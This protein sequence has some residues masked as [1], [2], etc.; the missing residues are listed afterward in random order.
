MVKRIIMLFFLC[1]TCQFAC[2]RSQTLAVKTNVLS[3][4][5]GSPNLALEVAL[6]GRLS[7]DVSGHY[8]PFSS[9]QS[10]RRRKHWLVQP[11]LRLW[12]CQPFS[13]HFIGLHVLAGE[14]NI[15]D[16]D[17]PASLY[18]GTKKWRYEG[19]VMGAGISYG[20]HFILS[21]HWGIEAVLGAG[22]VRASY[23]RY[24]CAHCGEKL[25]SGY[26]NY[27]GPTK[28]AI[29]MVYILR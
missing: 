1:G 22:F 4:A 14:Y 3:D 7:L 26:K 15:A 17:L 18:K 28:A 19:F 25:G 21:P 16:A 29:S 10:M 20:Y 2:L 11:E 9:E 6:G 13:G 23:D 27:L 5:V 8:N 12:R 24:R